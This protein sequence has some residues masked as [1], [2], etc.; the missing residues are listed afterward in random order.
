MQNT[1]FCVAVIFFL[2]VRCLHNIQFVL[3]Y[4]DESTNP[5]YFHTLVW[6]LLFAGDAA[7]AATAAASISLYYR[8]LVHIMYKRT[9]WEAFSNLYYIHA[10]CISHS[11][12][13]DGLS[14]RVIISTFTAC[15]FLCFS[16]ILVRMPWRCDGLLAAVVAAGFFFSHRWTDSSLQVLWIWVKP[17]LFVRRMC[18]LP[19]ATLTRNGWK[20]G[21][22]KDDAGLCLCV[23]MKDRANEFNF[24]FIDVSFSFILTN[25]ILYPW[26]THISPYSEIFWL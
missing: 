13:I 24:I 8:L 2:G 5:S 7:T 11:N 26:L 3:I 21:T 10:V 6:L 25:T 1:N 17:F 4:C 15:N 19:F 14:S 22:G 9:L 18:A 20:C 23:W 12:S 16:F